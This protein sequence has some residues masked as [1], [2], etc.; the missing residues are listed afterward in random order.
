MSSTLLA[1]SPS[2][3]P[4]PLPGSAKAP[5]FDSTQL[6][7]FF[8][9]LESIYE[10]SPVV[11]ADRKRYVGRYVPYDVEELRTSLPEWPPT[12]PASFTE[13]RVAVS[14]LYPE[15]RPDRKSAYRHLEELVAEWQA[16][17]LS[18]LE[19]YG[20]FHRSFFRIS[21]YELSSQEGRA[22]RRGRLSLQ[23][24]IPRRVEVP[25]T[26]L[27]QSPSQVSRPTSYRRVH[28]CRAAC[29]GGLH[30]RGSRSKCIPTEHPSPSISSTVVYRRA[31]F[32]SQSSPQVSP[33]HLAL[34]AVD[35][36]QDNSYASPST[37]AALSIAESDHSLL[38][39]S[40]RAPCEDPGSHKASRTADPQYRC[41]TKS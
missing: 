33:E 2:P 6:R 35:Q 29:G 19:D 4:L 3:P 26:S 41:P 25:T 10:R 31:V 30:S 37:H 28:A 8:D 36:E 22:G 32:K 7:R 24:D 13:F 1:P 40:W 16:Q 39:E 5:R 20:R 23:A 21:S 34:P 12:S 9:H 14:T 17:E 15:V 38:D 11:D 27:A 18:T